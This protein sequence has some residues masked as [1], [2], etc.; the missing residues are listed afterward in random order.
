MLHRRL[1]ACAVACA[2]IFSAVPAQAQTTTPDQGTLSTAS[3]ELTFT[4]GPFQVTNESGNTGVTSSTCSPAPLFACGLYTLTVD[5]PA[6]YD[7]THPNDVIRVFT[8]W[9]NPREDYDISIFDEAG[10]DAGNGQAVTETDPELAEFPAGAGSRTYTVQVYPFDVSGGTATTI[11]SL[12]TR[13]LTKPALPLA[14]TGAPPSFSVYAPPKGVGDGAGEPSIGYNLNTKRAM[15]LAGTS[16][17]TETLQVTFPENLSPPQP[18]VC[19]ASWKDVTLAAQDAGGFDPILYTDSSTGRTF[20]SHMLSALAGPVSE[21]LNSSFA[22]TDDDGATWVPAQIGPPE[23]GYDHQ[24]VAGGPYAAGA[25]PVNA[26][27]YPNAVYYCSQAGTTAYCARSDD[28]GLTFPLG[29]AIWNNTQGDNNDGC[30][31][32]HGHVRVAPDGTVYVPNPHCGLGQATAISEDSGASWHLSKIPG[33][34]KGE[35]DP[36][37]GLSTDGSGYFC[38][39]NGD[40]HPHVAVTHD[41]GASWINDYDIGALA[42]IQNAVFATA[43]A[44][45]ADRA[46]CA[47]I[48][49]TTA[50]NHQSAD[51]EG[52]WY[53][54]IATTYDGGKSWHTVN[55][56]PHD[57]VQREGGIWNG[58][59]SHTNR[60][61]L[62]FNEIALDEK[63][64]PLFGYADGCVDGCVQGGAN[65]YSS[66]ATIARLTGGRS[67][68]AAFD[69]AA[70]TAGACAKSAAVTASAPASTG[71]TDV[72]KF[73]GALNLILLLPLLG[74]ALRKLRR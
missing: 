31:G 44:G 3:P 39:V 28:G 6:D 22:Y 13:D 65:S 15:F 58:G 27:L 71:K 4:A 5:L 20:V 1:A 19:D 14:P 37:I 62:D 55:A 61:L 59:G 30:Q 56:S 42:N 23:G 70:P 73:G 64:R 47:F 38:Y 12:A 51:F 40:G 41:K 74:S 72:S 35:T 60:N 52:I 67:L 17:P 32:L 36:S 29:T 9:P 57:P 26:V 18:E 63:G 54:F 33:S 49:T 8:K 34:S 24:T 25:K 50:G 7:K 2:W 48:G 16:L 46:S 10:N 43:I 21:G 66:R 68:Y 69:G 45:D 53:P 11:I